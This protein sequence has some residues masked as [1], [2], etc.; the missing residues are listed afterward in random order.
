MVFGVL[1][2]TG[3]DPVIE[4]VQ[5]SGSHLKWPVS[6]LSPVGGIALERSQEKHHGA[7]LVYEDLRSPIGTHTSLRIFPASSNA[8]HIKVRRPT[9]SCESYHEPIVLF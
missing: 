3:K 5:S 6:S 7:V 4:R 9:R 2:V 1:H 8:S